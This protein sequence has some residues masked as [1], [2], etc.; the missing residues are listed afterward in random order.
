MPFLFIFLGIVPITLNRPVWRYP[1]ANV[2]NK[3]CPCGSNKKCYLR[4]KPPENPPEDEPETVK[5]PGDRGAMAILG[6][7]GVIGDNFPSRLKMPR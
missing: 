3:L 4:P 5:T 7:L 1:L 2:R 6:S